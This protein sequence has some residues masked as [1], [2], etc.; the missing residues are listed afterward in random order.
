MI[1]AA[2]TTALLHS[3]WQGAILALIAAAAMTLLARRSA[4]LRHI[5]GM[6]LL[7]AMA[8]V[9][10]LTFLSMLDGSGGTPGASTMALPGLFLG[11]LG[12]LPG[13]PDA[14]TPL[15][16]S[17]LWA[18]GVALMLVR[19]AGGWSMVR[20]LDREAFAPLPPAWQ[21]RADALRRTLGIRRQVAIR[22]LNDSV[23]PCSA[24]AL[25]PVIWLPVSILARLTADQIEALIAH[26]LAHIRRLDWIWN[27]LQCA[28]EALM[29]YHPG[30]WWLSRRIRAERENACDDL[31]VAACGDPISLAEALSTL[32]RLR[33]PAPIFVLP[34]NGG[35]L[36]NRIKRLLSPETPPGLRWGVPIGLVA[37]LCSGAVIATQAGSALPRKDAGVFFWGRLLGNSMEIHDTVDGK[38]RLY[39]RASDLHGRVSEDFTID[40][41]PAPIDAGV[42]QWIKEAQIVP[43]PPLPPAP[44][45]PPPPFIGTAAY[46][47]A[48]HLVGSDP[49]LIAAIGQPVSALGTRG[50]SYLDDNRADMTIALWGPKGTAKLHAVGTRKG[51]AWQFERLEVSPD[52]GAHF[53]LTPAR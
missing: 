44:P 36:V 17:W 33:A 34:A 52:P 28:I 45:L 25:R 7:V 2:L 24:R 53:D 19:L 27:G 18:T 51:D 8:V 46:Q 1:E 4:A 22:L 40:G 32:E 38:N 15:W 39:R 5:V 42:R 16:L 23:L 13:G 30:V 10:L 12:P 6:V 48:A 9:P 21:A 47:S 31:A 20:R 37:L 43:P 29:F 14:A 3:L 26:E 35:L 41:R 50:P 49:R 11:P